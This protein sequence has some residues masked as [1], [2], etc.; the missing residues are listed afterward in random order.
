MA[1]TLSALMVTDIIGSVTWA[2][3]GGTILAASQLVISYPI[4][5]LNDTYGRKFGMI[6]AVVLGLVGAALLGLS[7]VADSIAIFVVGMVVLGFGA[8]AGRQIRV[9]AAD[10]YPPSRRGEGLGFVLTGTIIGAFIAPF[11]VSGGE[12]LSDITAG[13][14]MALSWFLVPIFLIPAFFC[15]L[16]VR[17]DPKEIAADLSKYWPGYTSITGPRQTGGSILTFINHRPKQVAYACFAAA[18]GSM[19]MM[20]IMTPVILIESGHS[21]RAISFTVSLH[22]VGMF[23]LS[24][25]IGRAADRMGRKP[26][27]AL[28]LGIAMVGAAILPLTSEYGIITFGLFLVGVGWSA[29]NVAS[30]AILADTTDPEERGRAVGA[31]DAI[32]N[33]FSMGIPTIAGVIAGASGLTGVGIAGAA[34]AFLPFVLLGRLRETAPGQYDVGEAALISH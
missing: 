7:L 34:L 16:K 28:G 33:G 24:M 23:G 8:G 21:L 29:V 20:M 26:M 15:I 1:I 14:P 11:I 9:A 12:W 32:G 22:T 4:G 10:M 2:G 31:N 5:K 3:I 6:V 19:S 18:Q 30:T 13:E 27:L 25:I 17:P